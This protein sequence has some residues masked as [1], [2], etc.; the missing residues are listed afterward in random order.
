MREMAPSSPKGAKA[1]KS[2][3]KRKNVSDD[4]SVKV[5]KVAKVKKVPSAKIYLQWSE[6]DELALLQIWQDQAKPFYAKRHANDINEVKGRG[7]T[8]LKHLLLADVLQE[9]NGV[10]LAVRMALT[11]KVDETGKAVPSKETK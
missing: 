8:D 10:S 5:A 2:A 1:T 11:P 4:W 9:D 3:V 7:D 6:A